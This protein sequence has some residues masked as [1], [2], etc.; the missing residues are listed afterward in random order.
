[1]RLPEIDG[2]TY[3][4]LLGEDSFGWSYAASWQGEE[5]RVVK[6]LKSQATSA[7]LLELYFQVLADENSQ[8]VG[9]APVYHYQLGDESTP[10]VYTMPHYGWQSRKTG[11]WQLT[12]LKRLARYLPPESALGVIRNLAT[13]LSRVHEQGYFH[14]GLKPGSLFLEADE[15]GN[16]AVCI[17]DFGQI[18]MGGLDYLRGG[19]LLFYASPEQLTTGDFSEEKGFRWDIYSFGVIAFQLLTGHLPRLELFWQQ[20]S[21][22]PA[23]LRASAAIAYSEITSLTEHFITQLDQEKPVEWPDEAGNLEPALRK[24]IEACLEFDPESRPGSMVE[25]ER[26]LEDIF[27]KTK[28][29]ESR[30]R[31]SEKKAAPTPV[32]PRLEEPSP[33]SPEEKVEPSRELE[34]VSEKAPAKAKTAPA[35]PVEESVADFLEP[36]EFEADSLDDFDF[37]GD[38]TNRR[39][40]E[41]VPVSRS[42]SGS[43][44]KVA[45]IFE[46]RTVLKWQIAAVGSMVALLPISFFGLK[47]FFELRAVRD[48]LTIEAAELQASVEQQAEAYRR[49]ITEKQ[50]SSEQLRSELNN[51]E[52]SKSQ[53]VGEAKLARQIV[54][55]TQE[56]GDEFFQLVLNNEDTDVPGFREGRASALVQAQRHY[57]RLIEVYGDA[58]DF[59]V[60]TANAFFY[61]GRIYQEVGEFGKSLA[62]FGE[63]ERRYGVLLED[64]VTT[65]V[66]FVRNLAIAKASLGELSIKNTEYA[67]A[68]HYF[69]ESSRYWADVRTT[70]PA[71][72]IEATV[73]IHLNSLEIV[74]C[75]LAID[76]L[77]AALD[78]ARSV[79]IQVLKLQDAN[80]ENHL[81]VGTLARSFAL[82]G[83]IL[84]ARGQMDLAKEAFTQAG[85]LYGQAVTLNA[86]VDRYQLGLGN[87]FARL[88]LINDDI[89]KLKV[90]IDVLAR[91]IA[92]NPFESEYQKTLADVY[93]VLARNQRDG[94]RSENAI[95]LEQ[96]AIS[97]LQ[98]IIRE[99]E[100][101]VPSDVLYS[102]SQR[103]AHLAEL[104]GDAGNFDESRAPLEE[105][106]TVLELI[107]KENVSI[108]QYQ[109]TLARARGLAGFACLKSGDESE[110]KEHLEL[111]RISW[112]TYMEGNPDD[113]DAKQAVKWTSDQLENLQ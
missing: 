55:Q 80:P 84:E 65:D 18:F 106:I 25:V 98:P 5:R 60:S 21:E 72:A 47:N 11:Q 46:G 15:E 69:T 83:R 77:D 32:V 89:E 90:A 59:I 101:K 71:D 22:R 82:T 6:V 64:S 103:L 97:I 57:E 20:C 43:S 87:S 44:G 76:R 2:Y 8:I 68:R 63:A 78:G 56:N 1:M 4:D 112:E 16:Q 12:S 17:G 53:L 41:T 33:I 48:E 113:T 49:A 88:G 79:G 29:K 27:L 74:E 61:L 38:T 28:R 95:Q 104:L 36:E 7:P 58:P 3:E 9:A 54:R 73:S 96:E 91:V 75:E 107:S 45:Q 70:S 35:K 10:S 26:I 108:S 105:A 67:I 111:A 99:N 51:V 13:S 110:A 39:A 34:V 94:G 24:V 102:Y 37:D 62:S 50:K 14:G 85:D 92:K 31:K 93:G 52:A 19:D 81:V 40:E 42:S 30:R 23:A 100:G 109:R 86:A 66:N